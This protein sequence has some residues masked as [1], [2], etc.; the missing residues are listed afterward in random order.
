MTVRINWFLLCVLISMMGCGADDVATQDEVDQS[1]IGFTTVALDANKPVVRGGE[2]VLGNLI[3]DSFLKHAIE[4]G[5]EVDFAMINGGNIR[6]D[7]SVHPSGIYPIGELTRADVN[8]I[9][10]F[11]NTGIIIQITGAELKSTLERSVHELPI[12]AGTNGGGAFLQLSAGVQ[13]IVDTRQQTQ[14]IDELNNE[15][16]I[17]TEGERIIQLLINGES[18]DL[19]KTYL[20]LLSSFAASGGDGFIVVGNIE[21]T[22][23]IDLGEPLRN[24][25]EGYLIA[26]TP[27]SPIIE[28]RILI[29][30]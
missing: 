18:L 11:N 20:V 5:F 22:R 27:V 9:L 24:A 1:V 10:P 12:P 28:N 7:S 3:A 8:E 14:V 21:Q 29:D 2:S 13:V 16:T 17:V 6:F 4:K 25:L 19:S 23:K 26:N 15:M 30:Q